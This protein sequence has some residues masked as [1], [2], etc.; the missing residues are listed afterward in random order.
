MY[1]LFSLQPDITEC[2]QKEIKK[3]GLINAFFQP[4]KAK[5]DAK[6]RL[7][8]EVPASS[9]QE[10]S[11][12]LASDVNKANNEVV[13]EP[14]TS[15]SISKKVGPT[16]KR[17]TSNLSGKLNHATCTSDQESSHE[18]PVKPKQL[19][20]KWSVTCAVRNSSKYLNSSGSDFEDDSKGVSNAKTKQTQKSGKKNAKSGS[21]S[22]GGIGAQESERNTS[23]SADDKDSKS[24]AVH[25]Q[26]SNTTKL[27][28]DQHIEQH[29][30]TNK[31]DNESKA[32]GRSK[33]KIKQ[34]RTS[35]FDVLMKS[36]R[37]QKLED[38]RT[39]ISLVEAPNTAIIS[40]DS[41][42]ETSGS[43][44][45]VDDEETLESKTNVTSQ[46]KLPISMVDSSSDRIT[47]K[48]SS[49]SETNAFDFLM[50]KGRLAKSPTSVDTQLESE[51]DSE[52]PGNFEGSS[53]KK[54]KKKSFEFQLSIRASKKKDIDF[55]LESDYTSGD[56]N[57]EDQS[58]GKNKWKTRKQ[59]RDGLE[60]VEGQSDE[61]FVSDKC[62]EVV[63][64][65]KSRRGR[66]KSKVNADED[67]ADISA[68]EVTAAEERNKSV[69][70]GRKAKRKSA[71]GTA[72]DVVANDEAEVKP[73]CV[74]TAQNKRKKAKQQRKDHENIAEIKDKK[75]R[76]PTK[77]RMKSDAACDPPQS[78]STE[79]PETSV[80]YVHNVV[81]PL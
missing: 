35:A 16:S 11:Q 37:V 55:S 38:Q 43:C 73:E 48:S 68:C 79:S 12:D 41:M 46:S 53:K 31:S 49:S 77:K 80:W 17:K 28:L 60:V 61:S 40:S 29:T 44:E 69:K 9:N 23:E 74:E 15:G 34:T 3:V 51:L 1:C 26:K 70:K 75:V 33:E 39:E 27:V 10:S 63:G 19:K 52:V 8:I 81:E 24:R 36:Q 62:E 42:L 32:S 67:K 50:K 65:S 6:T 4:I 72:K 59:K 66:K 64:V 5:Q 45:I 57:C 21:R 13:Q 7:G 78:L 30:E 76:K 47:G 25:K 54:S 14:N 18:E 71:S 58:K 22:N 20:P 56:V 2:G